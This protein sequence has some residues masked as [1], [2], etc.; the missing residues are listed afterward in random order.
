[1]TDLAKPV[2]TLLML[3]RDAELRNSVAG[4]GYARAA[5]FSIGRMVNGYESFFK[6]KGV[7]KILKII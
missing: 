1:M 3:A 7:W 5:D 4:K 2:N 6:G